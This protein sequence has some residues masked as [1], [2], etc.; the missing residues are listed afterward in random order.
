MNA[1]AEIHRRIGQQGAI[2][3]AEFMEL[4]L[5]WPQGG[6]YVS[7]EPIG[8]EGDFY[9]SPQVHPVFGAL[10]AVQ[11]FQM[12]GL[13]GQPEP[14]T[15]VE[16]GAGNGILC[17]DVVAASEHLPAGFGRALRYLC[18]DLRTTSGAETGLVESNSPARVCRVAAFGLPFKRVVGCIL[19]NEYLDSFPVHQLTMGPEGLREVYVTR[20]GDGL[21]TSL[22]EP[23]T[24]GLAERLDNLGIELHEGQIAEIN[25]GLEPW[26]EAAAKALDTGFVLTVDY[27]HPAQDLYSPERRPRGT[28]TT[29]Y[30]HTQIDAPLRHIGRQDMTAQVDFTSVVEAGRRHGLQ[31][32]GFA[33][34]SQFVRHLGL[35]R[36]QQRLAWLG[37]SQDAAQANRAGMLDLARPGGLGD[38]KVL[39][40]GKGV[41][42]SDLW[43][44][45]SSDHGA[46]AEEAA[47]LVDSLPVPLLTPQHLSLPEGL[48][49]EARPSQIQTSIEEAWLFEGDPAGRSDSE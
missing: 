13:L 9:T 47:A 40:Q 25:L 32:W 45:H 8:S 39:V 36:M 15:V 42:T 35:G 10:L 19:S 26:A 33:S 46:T 1:E 28:L 43:G 24:T 49:S 6:Y 3:F 27:G 11:L 31:P 18:L 23:S 41:A 14:F 38:F 20:E 30:R 29:Y 17:R 22:G 12:W 48:Y 34:Q 37:L 7:G 5:F 44:F 16:L 2:T 21:Q 4:A